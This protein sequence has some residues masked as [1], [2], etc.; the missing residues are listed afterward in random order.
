MARLSLADTGLRSGSWRGCLRE[1]CSASVRGID[2]APERAVHGG[3]ARVFA[4]EEEP[5]NALRQVEPD[6][7]DRLHHAGGR[8]AHGFLPFVYAGE[9]RFSLHG[10]EEPPQFR[11]HASAR[12]LM[13]QR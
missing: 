3:N 1:K 10:R 4:G 5:A 7:L 11:E 2:P 6:L 12:L 9:E 13:A 8:Q